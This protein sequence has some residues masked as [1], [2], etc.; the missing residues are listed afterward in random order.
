ML[1]EKKSCEEECQQRNAGSIYESWFRNVTIQHVE[2]LQK[3]VHAVL[4]EKNNTIANLRVELKC[5]EKDVGDMKAA[6]EDLKLATEKRMEYFRDKYDQAL[7]AYEKTLEKT[8]QTEKNNKEAA[9]QIAKQENLIFKL[10]TKLRKRKEKLNAILKKKKELLQLNDRKDSIIVAEKQKGCDLSDTIKQKETALIQQREENEQLQKKIVDDG[11]ATVLKN[12]KYL[13][14]IAELKEKIIDKDIILQSHQITIDLAKKEVVSL[15]EIIAAKESEILKLGHS[16]DN[17][18][19]KEIETESCHLKVQNK[20][21]RT[22]NER[23]SK[24]NQD[25][26]VTV[27]NLQKSFNG[28]MNELSKLKLHNNNAVRK[29]SDDKPSDRK[30]K[31]LEVKDRVET[32]SEENKDSFANLKSKT[33]KNNKS[34]IAL[35]N[36]RKK[37]NINNP[38]PRAYETLDLESKESVKHINLPGMSLKPIDI[39]IDN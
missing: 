19:F 9:V 35:A 2:T 34:L 12:E 15:T 22:L 27:S 20:E 5:L 4:K 17:I 3:H 18:K 36:A 33:V 16:G 24:E 30:G 6:K 32:I 23:V 39:T 10:K 21:L 29:S 8:A 7:K 13:D 28:K 1:P 31:V 14:E 37:M 26:K 38:V 25:L 11:K